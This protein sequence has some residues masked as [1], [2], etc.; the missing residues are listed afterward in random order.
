MSSHQ[1]KIL[2][3]L[4]YDAANNRWT[5]A[6]RLVEIALNYRRRISDLCEAGH[7]IEN[8]QEYVNGS[9]H[10]WYRLLS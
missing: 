8:K 5:S 1:D 4:R 6:L 3:L 7:V 2:A 9:N 10:S